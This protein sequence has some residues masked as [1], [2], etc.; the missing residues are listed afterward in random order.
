L[1]TTGDEILFLLKTRGPSRTGEIATRL[2]ISRQ[3]SRQQLERLAAEGLISAET[4]RGGVGRPRRHWSLTAKGHG[5]FPDSHAQMTIDLIEAVR[6][7]FGEDGLERLIARRERETLR[8]YAEAAGNG[9]LEAR[10]EALA[11]LRTDE[12]Y[13]AEWRRDEDGSFLFVESHCP[14][15]A[16]ARACQSLCRSELVTFQK[17][18]GTSC[19]VER[20]D[21]LLAG[22][23]RCAYRIAPRPAA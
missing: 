16:A 3:G 8:H 20:L 22:A 19:T 9:S 23:R 12:G 5:R 1:K 17:V 13:M 4:R 21:H 11:K 18:L 7:E 14:I 10:V 15:C 2:G 6:G